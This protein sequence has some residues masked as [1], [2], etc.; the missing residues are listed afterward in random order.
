MGIHVRQVGICKFG[1]LVRE[2]IPSEV[3]IAIAEFKM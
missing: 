1:Q 3:E 2:P